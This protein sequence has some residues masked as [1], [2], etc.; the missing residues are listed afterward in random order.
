MI[1]LY[2]LSNLNHN[3]TDIITK[4]NKSIWD[5]DNGFSKDAEPFELPWKVFGDAI[6]DY[7][8][9]TLSLKKD[10]IGEYCPKTKMG[11]TVFK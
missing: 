11:S 9:I 2:R 6:E 3:K 7:I 5:P 1:I 10:D 8:K 4:A